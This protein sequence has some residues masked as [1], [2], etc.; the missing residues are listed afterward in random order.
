M[1]N[2]EIIIN[3]NYQSKIILIP[4]KAVSGIIAIQTPID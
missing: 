3:Q 1:K 4:V 2:G